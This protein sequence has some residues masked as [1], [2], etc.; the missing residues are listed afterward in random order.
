MSW[1]TP[2]MAQA[3]E[4]CVRCGVSRGDHSR[5]QGGFWTEKSASACSE[6]LAPPRQVLASSISGPV[7]EDDDDDGPSH[8]SDDDDPALDWDTDNDDSTHD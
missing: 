1:G 7:A 5:S 8:G 3:A 6:Y 4:R 2:T